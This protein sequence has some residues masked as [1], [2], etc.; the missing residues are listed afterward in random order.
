LPHKKHDIVAAPK[1][2]A[3]VKGEP[4]TL[5]RYLRPSATMVVFISLFA[6][7]LTPYTEKPVFSVVTKN[8]NAL[9]RV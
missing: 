5:D 6:T 2:P 1:E 3:A 4:A 8:S 9:N 7:E